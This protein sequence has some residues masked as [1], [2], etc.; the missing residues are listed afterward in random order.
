MKIP[1]FQIENYIQKI[2]AEKI[3]GCLL[4]G[5]EAALVNYRF[6]LIAK[7]I[8]PDLSDPFL[9]TNISKEKLVEDKAILG[10]EFFSYSM[11]GG[12][13]INHYR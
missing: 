2:A 7:K 12:R 3:A 6:N 11:L 8:A 10:D 13:K 4:F 9:V 1:P 5:P